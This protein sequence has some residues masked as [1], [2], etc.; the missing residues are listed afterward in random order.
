MFHPFFTTKITGT[1]LGLS[2]CHKIVAAH[3]GSLD[4]DSVVGKGS[5][6]TIYLPLAEEK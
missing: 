1:G 6:F 3:G 5:A 4:V 2:I